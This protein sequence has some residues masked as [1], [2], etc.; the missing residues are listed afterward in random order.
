MIMGNERSDKIF[1]LAVKYQIPLI[2]GQIWPISDEAFNDFKDEYEKWSD[3]RNTALEE[4][5]QR[6]PNLFRTFLPYSSRVFALAAKIVWYLDEIVIRDPVSVVLNNPT[7]NIEESK[8]Q[9]CQVLAVL[10]LF[11]NPIEDGYILLRGGEKTNDFVLK[12]PSEISIRLA[13]DYEVRDRLL[14]AASYSYVDKHDVEG[15]RVQLYKA[16][17]DG[18]GVMGFK[19]EVPAGKTVSIP[20]NINTEYPPASLSDLQS[21]FG[22]EPVGKLKEIFPRF[23]ERA[24]KATETA[25]KLNSA[26]LFDD[27]VYGYILNKSGVYTNKHQQQATAGTLDLML[28][29]VSGVPAEYLTELR[30][31]MPDAFL[32]FRSNMLGIVKEAMSCSDPDDHLIPELVRSKITPQ[33][34]VLE[35]EITSTLKK[36]RILGLG[37]PIVSGVAMLAGGILAAPITPL[38]ALGVGGA[39]GGV[40]AAA[41]YKEA[42]EKFKSHPFYFL[43]AARN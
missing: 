36:S 28:P 17:L 10:S 4:H 21:I 12:E 8:I 22:D 24:I 25:Y 19:V 41:D 23:V 26:V 30:S 5:L 39:I 16:S 27:E 1:E 15:N 34:R 35:G 11:R 13:N 40:K 32:D 38:L 37:I 3:E 33:L 14:K 42:D 43:W 18:G 20:I 2:Q 6:R 29:F 9:L 31:K 7:L